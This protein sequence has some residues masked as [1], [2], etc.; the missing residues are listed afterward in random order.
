[1]NKK[2]IA[3][4]GLIILT[5][6]LVIVVFLTA[7]LT[8][9][10]QEIRKKAAG[11]SGTVTVNFNPESA[12]YY[13]GQTFV[14]QIK[15]NPGSQSVNISGIQIYLQYRYT[16][17]TPPLEVQDADPDVPGIQIQTGIPALTYVDNTVN[18]DTANKTVTIGLTAYSTAGYLLDGED[19]FGSIT[20]LARSP[21]A[22]NLS[23]IANVSKVI[24]KDDGRDILLTPTSTA[25]YTTIED[26]VPP[27]TNI[28]SGPNEGSVIHAGNVVFGFSGSDNETPAASLL[29]SWRL[30]GPTPFSWS[31][32][33]TNTSAQLNN[34]Q[35][36]NY[37]FAVKA[38]DRAGL[39]D[40]TPATRSFVVDTKSSLT[41]KIKFQGINDD[42]GVKTAR[43][44]LRSVDGAEQVFD[45]VEF[46]HG[47]SGVYVAT[48]HNLEPGAYT[49]LV[50]SWA[51]LQKDFGSVNLNI[52]NNMQDFSS[53]VLRAGDIA[54]GGPQQ[55]LPDNIVD[56]SDIGAIIKV[57]NA[58]GPVQDNIPANL[59]CDSVIDVEDIGLLITNFDPLGGGDE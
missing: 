18:V 15:I 27:E 19:V 35:D 38:K 6:F 47:D 14:N 28:I 58:L 9:E 26:T 31:G 2:R 49:V 36:G 1:M 37:T 5:I 11:P 42:K 29:Y 30:N 59:N 3:L 41:L 52:G 33:S 10:K 16:G 34:L 53:L 39:I 21:G 56:V 8:Q 51:H 57:F 17:E 44:I 12:S 13:L 7:Q 54:G 23:F 25:S 46:S 24:R 20:F 40:P 32:F 43:V 22:T 48:V 50:K 4:T 45:N 55:D